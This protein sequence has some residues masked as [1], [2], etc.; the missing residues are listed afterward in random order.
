M[1]TNN[2]KDVWSILKESFYTYLKLFIY[3]FYFL[4][5]SFFIYISNAIPKAPPP[6]TLPLPCSPTHPLLLP[7]PGTPLYWD[8]WSSQDQGPLFPLMAD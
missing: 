6:H 3:F 2:T 7:G 5:D 1:F 4:L 8:I